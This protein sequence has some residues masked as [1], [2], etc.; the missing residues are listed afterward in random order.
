MACALRHLLLCRH[1]EKIVKQLANAPIR[2]LLSRGKTLPYTTFDHV[3]P[4]R[5][6]WH[7]PPALWPQ[8]PP[9][10]LACGVGGAGAAPATQQAQGLVT[11][12][13][14]AKRL[15]LA[16]VVPQKTVSALPCPIGYGAQRPWLP[17]GARFHRAHGSGVPRLQN[18]EGGPLA[19][20][21][22]GMQ[23][24]VWCSPIFPPPLPPQ[25]NRRLDLSSKLYR[26]P[27]APGRAGGNHTPAPVYGPLPSAPPSEGFSP[28]DVATTAVLSG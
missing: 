16:P 8:T 11:S 28:V 3:F 9:G 10:I 22:A 24:T 18:S 14:R 23:Q 5:A 25:P 12:R 17:G 1:R 27:R 15:P 7:T 19:W 2:R 21:E 6:A 4:W 20:G 13:L 26:H